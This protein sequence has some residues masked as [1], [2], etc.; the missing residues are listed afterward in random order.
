MKP[1]LFRFKIALLALLMS[2]AVL[3]VFGFIFLRVITTVGMNRIDREIRA[4]AE[5]QLHGRH[6]RDHWTDFGRSLRF[7]HGDDSPT[8]VVVQVRDATGEVLYT[9]PDCPQQVAGMSQ[10]TLE[11]Q[12][13]PPDAEGE[14]PRSAIRFIERLDKDGD[15]KV[16]KEEFDG[17]KEHFLNFDRDAD[18]YISEEEAPR[19]PMVPPPRRPSDSPAPSSPH[20]FPLGPGQDGPSRPPPPR[21]RKPVFQTLVTPTDRWRVGVMGNDFITMVVAMDLAGFYGDAHRFKTAFLVAVPIAL[22]ALAAGGWLLAVRALRPVSII[23]RTVEAIT[24]RGL[25]KR[26]PATTADAE[27]A[28]LIHVVNGMLDRLERSFHQALRFSADAA[29]ELQTPLTILQGELEEAVQHAPPAS[30]QQ[31]RYSGLL[32]EVQQL[33]TIVQKLLLLARADAGQ[34]ALNRTPVD[35]SALLESAIEDTR[36]IAPHL[37]V[38][39]HIPDGILVM[40]DADLLGQVLGNMTTNAV[41]YNRKGGRVRFDLATSPCLAQVTV[42]NTGAPISEEDR[43]RIFDRFYRVD[44]SRSR[45]VSGSGLGLSLAREIARAHKGDLVVNPG[46]GEMV[47]FTLT[48]PLAEP[49]NGPSSS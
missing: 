6:P 43:D 33:K 34:L 42:S 23:T 1:V 20:G 22:M 21:M 11:F 10:P 18:G 28:G 39:D 14:S 26:V 38:E 12:G 45:I 2:G 29:H 32:E 47:S 7:I 13:P 16:S 31:Q 24:A 49:A 48:L 40:G 19:G 41:K 5:S 46:H 8:R 9:S 36:A 27:L 25:D 15:G 30:E 4:L 44:K 37:G 35:L 3:V 17:P